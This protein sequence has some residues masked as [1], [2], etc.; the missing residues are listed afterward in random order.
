MAE[1]PAVTPLECPD[2]H[3]PV[4]PVGRQ[5]PQMA[6]GNHRWKEH[7]VRGKKA[8]KKASAKRRQSAG[9]QAPAEPVEAPAGLAIVRNITD[10]L[11]GGKGA[12]SAGQLTS[13]IG[14]GYGYLMMFRVSRIVESDPRLTDDQR[15]QVIEALAPAPDTCEAVA[16]PL[17]RVIARSKVNRTVGRAIVDNIDYADALVALVE[18]ERQLA[19]Y[20]RELRQYRQAQDAGQVHPLQAVTVTPSTHATAGPVIPMGAEE[21]AGPGPAFTSPAPTDGV[22]VDAAMVAQA[23]GHQLGDWELPADV[24]TGENIAREVTP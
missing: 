16:S 18:T 8:D 11:E 6:L 7:G 12:P 1:A 24:N 19:R 20:S 9:R 17:A 22:V 14:R 2:C 21:G 10:P 3:Q 23:A 15:V 4:Q 13:A 5:T